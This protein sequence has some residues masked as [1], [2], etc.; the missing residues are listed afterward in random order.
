MKISGDVKKLF[1]AAQVKRKYRV[2]SRV[3]TLI[4]DNQP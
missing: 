4:P 1:D 2:L 3:L